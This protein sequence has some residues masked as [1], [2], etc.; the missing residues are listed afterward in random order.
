MENI[1]Q[2]NSLLNEKSYGL[3]RGGGSYGQFWFG[4]SIGF[5]GFLY[6]KN[7]GVGA[8]RSTKFAPGGNRNCNTYQDVNNSYVP[9]SGVGGTSIS[10][11][12]AKQR[13]ATICNNSNAVPAVPAVLSLPTGS[14]IAFAGTSSIPTGYLLCGGA[15]VSR[16]TYANLFAV[17]G[18]LY[19][20][21]AGTFRLPNLIHKFIRGSAINTGTI[22][23]GSL[24]I[25]NDNILKAPL[26]STAD[27]GNKS[28]VFN[29]VVSDYNSLQGDPSGD[30]SVPKWTITSTKDEGVKDLI[31]S[32]TTSIGTASPIPI[33]YSPHCYEM[34]YI[35]KF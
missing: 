20:G 13:Y 21:A 2:D 6:K 28:V 27:A 9:G 12:R 4:K 10:V 29:G 1:S 33:H 26:T 23:G 32:F 19:G 35:I 24:T 25:T 22:V 18:Y 34:I 31:G 16:T 5:P 30:G 17:I 11:R 3:Q 14:I 8:R 7:N 15:G